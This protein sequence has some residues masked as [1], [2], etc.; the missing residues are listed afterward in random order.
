LLVCTEEAIVSLSAHGKEMA[1]YFLW[2]RLF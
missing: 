2:Y 1:V